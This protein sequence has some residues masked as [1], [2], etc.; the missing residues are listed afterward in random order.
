MGT[1]YSWYDQPCDHCGRY[2]M[3][4][5]GKSSGGWSFLFAAYLRADSRTPFDRAVMSRSDWRE[6]FTSRSGRL[7]DEYGQQ[8]ADPVAWLDALVPPDSAQIAK[9]TTWMGGWIAED[10]RRDAEGFRIETGEFS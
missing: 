1:N 2:E 3:V 5:V 9:E 10:V 4:H 6:I 8:I 7:L